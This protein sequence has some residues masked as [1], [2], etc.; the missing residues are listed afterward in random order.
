MIP[1]VENDRSH[2]KYTRS[3]GEKAERDRVV[4]TAD[5]L[6]NG[7]GIQTVGMDELRRVSGLSLKAIYGLFPSKAHIV[8]AVLDRRHDAWTAALTARVERIPA[9]QKKLLA[10][11]D[12]LADWF[13]EDS[14]NGCGFINAFAELGAVAPEVAERARAHK[15]DF[16]RYVARLVSDAHGPPELAPQLA[17]LAEGAQTTAAISGTADAAQHARAAAEVLIRS[18]LP[19]VS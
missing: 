16:Q 14:F 9:P 17:I 2:L 10:I 18:A 13:S 8:L 15:I 19:V 7:R 11:Y 6:Y 5:E 1:T 12:Y 3:M 4:E